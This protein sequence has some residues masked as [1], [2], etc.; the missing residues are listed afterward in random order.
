[1]HLDIQDFIRD[2][3]ENMTRQEL[4]TLIYEEIRTA[5]NMKVGYLDQ[6]NENPDFYVL[7][8]RQLDR[9]IFY[10]KYL[11]NQVAPEPVALDQELFPSEQPELDQISDLMKRIDESEKNRY[12]S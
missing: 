3:P 7:I 9:Y 11:H 1:M 12:K 5:E 4:G 6:A 8:T 2:L 10:L